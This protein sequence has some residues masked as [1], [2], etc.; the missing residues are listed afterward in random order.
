MA[1][2][3]LAA[4]IAAV[5]AP[6]LTAEPQWDL[7]QY[8]VERQA[9]PTFGEALHRLDYSLA[10]QYWKGDEGQFRPLL[11]LLLATEYQFF[12]VDMR[13]WRAA[14]IAMHLLVAFF[15]F[16]LLRSRLPFPIAL[17]LSTLFG[18]MFASVGLVHNSWVG[19]YLAGCVLVLAALRPGLDELGRENVSSARPWMPYVVLM[20][21]AGFFFEV[22]VAFSLILAVCFWVLLSRRGLKV[23][24]WLGVLWMVPVLIFAVLYLPR[25]AIAPRFFFVH[26]LP[27]SNVLSRQHLMN[28]LLRLAEYFFRW[29][30]AV[31]VPTVRPFFPILFEEH[32]PPRLLA[33]VGLLINL[34]LVGG[35]AAM[36]WR[37]TRHGRLSIDATMRLVVLGCLLVGYVAV[38][39]FGRAATDET[40]RYIFALIAVAMLGALCELP[41]LA[42]RAKATMVGLLAGLALL[43]AHIAVGLTTHIGRDGAEYVRYL[44]SIEEFVQEHKN[45]PGFSFHIET[46][47]DFMREVMLLEGYPD[48]PTRVTETWFWQTFPGAVADPTEAAYSLTWDGE[49]ML[50]RP[51]NGR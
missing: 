13:W 11:I 20:T 25:I 51:T 30:V 34:G 22:F 4:A 41:G 36:L 40:H 43:N 45:E 27:D 2:L 21:L 17:A 9:W 6:G 18:V 24:A 3:V 38:V 23:P 48:Q 32:V 8:F 35:I 16:R 26:D 50:I 7:T 5:H 42:T 10:R 44:A 49:K 14:S 39:R 19:G 15:L 31:V 29:G 47:S 46:D 28:Y 1:L 12:G 33:R 37:F